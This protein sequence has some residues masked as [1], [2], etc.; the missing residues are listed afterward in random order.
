MNQTFGNIGG[1]AP[2]WLWDGSKQIESYSYGMHIGS[3]SL[4]IPG[5]WMLGGYNQ[6]RV[7][8]DVYVQ[9]HTGSSAPINLLDVSLDVVTGGSLWNSSSK[10]GLF[11]QGNFSLLGGPPS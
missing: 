7:L 1:I 2:G 4:G 11:A 3:Y 6:S 5:S 8:G 10:E 9:P